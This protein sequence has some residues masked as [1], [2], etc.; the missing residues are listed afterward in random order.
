MNNQVVVLIDFRGILASDNDLE[1]INR[2]NQYSRTLKK[3]T[4][5]D[6]KFIV[7]TF[8]DVS[9]LNKSASEIEFV[10]VS[11]NGFPSLSALL[12]LKRLFRKYESNPITIVAGDPW[13]TYWISLICK[14]LFSRASKLQVQ[15][16]ADV[17]SDI[18]PRQSLANRLRSKLVFTNNRFVNSIRFVSDGQYEKFRKK[19]GADKQRISIVPVP[20]NITGLVDELPDVDKSDILFVGRLHNDRGLDL[21]CNII[22]KLNMSSSE[23]SVHLVGTG[24][25]Q[26]RF[27]KAL[28][29]I[30]GSTRVKSHG[31]C[32]NTK[33][34]DI[35]KSCRL[36][37]ST[38]PSES[39]GRAMRESIFY[40]LPVWS[41]ANEGSL[42]LQKVFGPRIV[43]ILNPEKTGQQLFREYVE[44]GNVTVPKSVREKIVVSDLAGIQKL[45]ESW[46]WL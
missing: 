38:A 17:A 40:G 3:L 16:H 8:R 24:P 44:M 14:L 27:I 9:V 34:Q 20:L 37:L 46:L 30:C 32:V 21:F 19:Y 25:D 10:Q 35:T 42:E 36:I 29:S 43:R 41:V 6:S 7:V 13:E 26:T 31:F 45:V 4:H 12:N 15:V 22:E 11:R 23:F 2:H 33:V 5:K 1:T 39:Y 18:W 28:E